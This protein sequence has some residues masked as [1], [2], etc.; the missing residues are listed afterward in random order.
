MYVAR[1][2]IRLLS[3]FFRGSVV[4]GRWSVVVGRCRWLGVCADMGAGAGAAVGSSEF[5]GGWR[6]FQ[7]RAGASTV[8]RGEDQV[9]GTAGLSRLGGS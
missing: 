1:S 8:W 7:V 5:G 9:C 6:G 4:G 3:S 2:I